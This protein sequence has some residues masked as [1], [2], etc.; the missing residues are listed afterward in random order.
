MK[1]GKLVACLDALDTTFSPFMMVTLA[2]EIP[3]VVLLSYLTMI[4]EDR[5]VWMY[6]ALL[7]LIFLIG[8]VLLAAW[9]LATLNDQVGFLTFNLRRRCCW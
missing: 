1:Y 7:Q 4:S 2:A 9:S 8:P 5:P 6:L 3:N